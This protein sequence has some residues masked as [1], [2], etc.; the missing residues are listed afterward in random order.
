MKGD[1]A[2]ECM[3]ACEYDERIALNISVLVPFLETDLFTLI[4]KK[5][6]S[7]ADSTMKLVLSTSQREE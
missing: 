1:E 4:L 6:T 5:K 7:P 2:E 3:C